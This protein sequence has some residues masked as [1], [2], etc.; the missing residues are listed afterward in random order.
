MRTSLFKTLAALFVVAVCLNMKAQEKPQDKFQRA[1]HF[2][3]KITKT[4]EAD[5]L[6]FLPK[7]Y[8]RK[9]KKQWPLMLF[10]HGAG[11]RGTNVWRAD[12][13]GPSRYITNHAD[14]PFILVSP[15]CPAGD[16][17]WSN[18]TL[19]ALLDSVIK[20]YNADPERIYLTGLSMG[21]YGAWN[22]ALAH[23][24]KFAAVIP[25]CG[26][27]ETIHVHLARLKYLTPKTTAALKNLPIWAFH[28][29][30]DSAVPVNESEHMVES[31][32]ALGNKDV[33]LTIY[34]G[35]EHNSWEQ[36]YNNPEIYEWLLSHKRAAK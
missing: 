13:H 26:G 22:L 10:L 25:I 36:T 30:K 17:H 27:G 21:G 2:Q 31:F 7:G 24:E 32:K 19:S 15:I 8:D 33:K 20:K 1:E 34:P 9:A 29:S 35:V 28:G 18:E 5:Y 3:R 16:E 6:L 23:P 12:I 14:F 11:E 4:V